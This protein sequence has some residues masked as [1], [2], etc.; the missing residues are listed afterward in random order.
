MKPEERV[1]ARLQQL[2]DLGQSVLSTRRSPSPG[3]ITSDFVDTQLATRWLVS[4]LGLIAEAFGTD[5]IHYKRLQS[6]AVDYPKWPDA[7]QAFGVLL[8]AQD[9]LQHDALFSLRVLI[10]ADLF[11]NFLSQAEH[12]LQKGFWGPAAVVAGA[13]LEDALRKLCAREGIPLTQK[14][15]LDS[16]NAALAKSGQYTKLTQKKITA[17]ADVRN[18]AAH[19]KWTEFDS[20]DVEAMIRD[21]RDF[22][23]RYFS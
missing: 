4:S 5:S 2:V 17:L 10:E 6:H 16:M 12:L 1:K 7:N 18:N 9:D 14:P 3:H 15:K 23:E 8:A 22:M 20:T 13:V 19:G 11:E 21:V